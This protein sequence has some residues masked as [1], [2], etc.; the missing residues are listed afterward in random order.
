M[1]VRDE[2]DDDIHI[3]KM[4]PKR[5]VKFV[6]PASALEL[7]I[8]RM[9]DMISKVEKDEVGNFSFPGLTEKSRYSD[10]CKK[11]FWSGPFC[12]KI[13]QFHMRIFITEWGT[14][15]WRL[16]SEVPEEH[17]LRRNDVVIWNGPTCTISIQNFRDLLA[18]LI[19]IHSEA[20]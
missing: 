17:K 12:I 1:V 5:T 8:P 15:S 16:L 3:A 4:I 19:D 10:L 6:F 11:D 13:L 2:E 14:L 20:A 9:Q 7:L 18:A